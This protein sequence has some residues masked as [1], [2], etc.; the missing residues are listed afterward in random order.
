MLIS[1]QNICDRASA[2]PA[3]RKFVEDEQILEGGQIVKCGKKYQKIYKWRCEFYDWRENSYEINGKV[4]KDGKIKN[5]VFSCKAGL[6]KKCIHII[7]TLPYC[8][9]QV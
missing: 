2:N 3:Q 5:C 8:Y 1:I 4:L 9:R 7:A 6:G